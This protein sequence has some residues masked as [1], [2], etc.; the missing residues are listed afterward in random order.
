VAVTLT[1]AVVALGD[2]DGRF[3]INDF[4]CHADSWQ[5]VLSRLIGRAD[6]VLMDLRS[7]CASNAGCIYEINALLNAMPLAQLVL[8]VDDSTDLP[9][10]EQTLQACLRDLPPASPNAGQTLSALRLFD[11]RAVRQREVTRL[12]QH[13]CAAVFLKN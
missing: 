6:A 11:L 10:L 13:I 2:A 9:F 3:R 7:F 5:L 4:F 1:E 8:V 12:T